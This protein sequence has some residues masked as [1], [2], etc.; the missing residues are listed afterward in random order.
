VALY[1][2]GAASGSDRVAT[3]AVT[4]VGLSESAVAA[5]EAG[6]DETAT[7]GAVLTGVG[8]AD[9]TTV[10]FDGDAARFDLVRQTLADPAAQFGHLREVTRGGAD[11]VVTAGTG[12]FVISRS[13]VTEPAAEVDDVSPGNVPL[14]LTVAGHISRWRGLA[15]QQNPTTQ[16]GPADIDVDLLDPT[17]TVIDDAG[18]G[19]TLR[20]TD[21]QVVTHARLRI[22]NRGERPLFVAPL[23]LG[24]RFEIVPL[25]VAGGEWL[26]PKEEVFVP[27]GGPMLEFFLA[28]GGRAV[29]DRL[30]ILMATE[31]FDALPFEQGPVPRRVTGEPRG[32]RGVRVV[33]AGADWDARDLVV[34][35]L[36][37]SEP[38]AISGR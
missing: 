27:G 17:G 6:L 8:A 10:R 35:T 29:T 24:E 32:G 36:P 31:R 26:N 37:A 25:H 23:A 5:E 9:P 12:V 16:I 13:G 18:G 21:G 4:T 1:P 38:A 20:V 33:D 15:A 30:K 3:V 2:L 11:L 19:A 22:R 34:R 7:Y 14:V 28:E